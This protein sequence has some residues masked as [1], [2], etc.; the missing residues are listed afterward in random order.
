MHVFQKSTTPRPVS[1]IVAALTIA[2]C[3]AFSGTLVA[4][5][6]PA[7]SKSVPASKGKPA[8]IQVGDQV[9][10]NLTGEI[11]K[12]YARRM[13]TRV[14]DNAGAGLQISTSASVAQKLEDGRY[15]IEHSSR[16]QIANR[17]PRLITFT[18]TVESAQIN[19]DVV[20]KNTPVYAS[21]ADPA[22]GIKPS[23]TASDQTTYRIELSDPNTA[24]LETWELKADVAD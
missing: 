21:P 14:P 12:A 15:R 10:V 6:V 4:Q 8:N 24:K 20:P 7:Q 19:S 5:T 22:A 11:A 18:A 23:L 2:G 3:G 9:F 17:P 1:L 16:I 13:G